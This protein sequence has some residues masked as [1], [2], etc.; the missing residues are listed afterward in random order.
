[1]KMLYSIIIITI[2]YNKGI[3]AIKICFKINH[4]NVLII[5]FLKNSKFK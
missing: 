4:E 1:M 5:I 2:L 3:A